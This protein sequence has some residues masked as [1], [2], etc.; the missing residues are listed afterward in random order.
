M[1][2]NTPLKLQ[3]LTDDGYPYVGF[4]KT[5]LA[6]LGSLRR[7]LGQ[8]AMRRVFYLPE[9]ITAIITSCDVCDIITI[10]GG[11]PRGFLFHP[12][13]GQILL[14]Y[15]AQNHEYYVEGHGWD[16]DGNEVPTSDHFPLYD[17][18]H[19]TR[20]ISTA[21]REGPWK[22]K[23]RTPENYGNVDWKGDAPGVKKSE[24]PVL[25]WRGSASR[26]WG[27]GSGYQVYQNGEVLFQV[28]LEVYGAALTRDSD[29][30]VWQMYIATAGNSILVYAQPYKSDDS[31]SYDADAHPN[32]WRLLASQEVGSPQTET[33]KFN[34]FHFNGSGTEASS[35]VTRV[36]TWVDNQPV[37]FDRFNYYTV[38]IDI[39]Q[40][41]ASVVE[42]SEDDNGTT[43]VTATYSDPSDYDYDYYTYSDNPVPIPDEQAPTYPFY[44]LGTSSL[45]SDYF[46]NISMSK[47]G[48]RVAIDYVG[49][50]KVT[51]T[52]TR[53]K[54]CYRHTDIDIMSTY[55]KRDTWPWAV[56]TETQNHETSIIETISLTMAGTAYDTGSFEFV[57][58][59]YFDSAYSGVQKGDG[60]PPIEYS[61]QTSEQD[62]VINET[63]TSVVFADLRNNILVLAEQKRER[64]HNKVWGNAFVDGEWEYYDPVITTNDN[65]ISAQLIIKGEVAVNKEYYQDAHCFSKQEDKVPTTGWSVPQIVVPDD[66]EDPEAYLAKV[67][68]FGTDLYRG[69]VTGSWSVDVFGNHFYSVVVKDEV[70]T[71]LTGCD[72][73]AGLT[74][75]PDPNQAYHPIAPL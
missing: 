3:V 28:G 43:T 72:N 20:L 15:A 73:V 57:Y 31:A 65:I 12:R 21:K 1:D 33:L 22:Y 25:T 39:D 27:R 45:D 35:C 19:C 18:D 67:E 69:G 75:T 16:F 9:D 32:G 49:D 38:T 52:M 62:L 23:V 60:A 5:K 54:E 14:G 46:R 41:T 17:N 26:Y 7:Q 51:M 53:E 71:Y 44:I 24:I 2:Q 68:N 40:K 37:N 55:S 70:Y 61:E 58:K 74:Q 4:C 64:S 66:I 50:E 30:K 48:V 63:T 29:G 42:T 10:M 11:A 59:T 47:V 8:Y 34:M 56:G 36:S 6:A 13:C